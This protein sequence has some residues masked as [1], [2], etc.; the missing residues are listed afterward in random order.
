MPCICP[1]AGPYRR[2]YGSWQQALLHFG[3]T[4]DQVAERLERPSWTLSRRVQLGTLA[5]APPL[6]ATVLT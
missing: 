1:S 4:P 2:R 5:D 3:Y 6:L